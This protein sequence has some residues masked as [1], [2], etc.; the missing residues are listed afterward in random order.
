VLGRSKERIKK[1]SDV[2]ILW[3]MKRDRSFLGRGYLIK[4]LYKWGERGKKGRSERK[5]G[6][7]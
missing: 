2:F 5:R 3:A 6:G 7:G 4:A 1:A